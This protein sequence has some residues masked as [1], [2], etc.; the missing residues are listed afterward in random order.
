MRQSGPTEIVVVGDPAGPAGALVTESAVHLVP[1]AVRAWGEPYMSPLW[2][3][4]SNGHAYV[5]QGYACGKPVTTPE[6]LRA[7]LTRP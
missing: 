1:N 3:G 2:E 4:R 7:Q 6:A 5:C